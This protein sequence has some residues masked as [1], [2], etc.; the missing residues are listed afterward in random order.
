MNGIQIDFLLFL[1]LEDL[2]K[3]PDRIKHQFLIQE[4]GLE[5]QNVIS[6]KKERPRIETIPFADL[7]ELENIVSGLTGFGEI[8]GRQQL[9]NSAQLNDI[10]GNNFSYEGRP[11]VVAAEMIRIFLRYGPLEGSGSIHACQRFIE[12]IRDIPDLPRKDHEFLG[13]ILEKYSFHGKR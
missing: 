9:I 8:R 7:D 10:L 13:Q 4:L 2:K 12:V 1:H 5:T 3:E 11:K 6:G